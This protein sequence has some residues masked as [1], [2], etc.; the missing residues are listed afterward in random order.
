MRAHVDALTQFIRACESPMTIAIQGGWGTGKTTIINLI[1][2]KLQQGP[3]PRSTRKHDPELFTMVIDTWSL[4]HLANDE[5][6]PGAF[7]ETVMENLS[8]NDAPFK[9]TLRVLK[10]SLRQFTSSA[11]AAALPSM[12]GKQLEEAMNAA[13]TSLDSIGQQTDI[14]ELFQKAV[15]EK[16]GD[17]EGRVVIFV[18]NLDRLPPQRAVQI[19]ETLNLFFESK[20]CVFVLAIDFDVVAAGTR[21]IYGRKMS[22]AKAKL[23]F[24]K[25]IQVPFSIPSTH[26]R[27]RDYIERITPKL[28][29]KA[30]RPEDWSNTARVCLNSNPR[31][32]KRVFNSM[33]LLNIMSREET[34]N[35]HTPLQNF[36]LFTI[37]CIQVR[38]DDLGSR[39]IEEILGHSDDAD[40]TPNPNAKN[41][42][43]KS[44]DSI[45]N[46]PVG[47]NEVL[48]TELFGR[49]EEGFEKDSDERKALE[50]AA[51]LC[52]LTAIKTMGEASART[53]PGV[54]AAYDHFRNRWGAGWNEDCFN[55]FAETFT[56]IPDT[57]DAVIQA[58]TYE[59]LF[60]R[61]P[62][63]TQ[64]N[65][66]T[67]KF[68]D[69]RMTARSGFTPYIQIPGI[70][71]HTEDAEIDGYF[72]SV[73]KLAD[74]MKYLK[75]NGA[76]NRPDQV[77]FR[78][79]NK[80]FGMDYEMHKI[81][82]P[83]EAAAFARFLAA[84]Y[85]HC[86]TVTGASETTNAR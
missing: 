51:R 54:K 1:A 46:T 55:A 82:T 84:F 81:T 2:Q 53:Q 3:T 16:V 80:G 60:L 33:S 43:K 37:L 8:A 42:T 20:Q 59:R 77:I 71:A 36:F 6:I 62:A 34:K 24:D 45:W 56:G 26:E 28:N 72:Q 57:Q 40:Q 13:F 19:M 66:R 64:V 17:K 63:S 75:S 14:T 58:S 65:S 22:S 27:T 39:L 85:Q 73:E 21:A 79:R 48:L 12:V 11:I 86:L 78:C 15:K 10:P 30:E 29:I 44:K 68:A 76:E 74:T 31:A 52:R 7:A 69:L 41:N 83:E 67:R 47:D 49:P 18:D 70:P 32:I 38:D 5:D 4:S 25:I 35:E 9:K 61:L 50:G 23:F